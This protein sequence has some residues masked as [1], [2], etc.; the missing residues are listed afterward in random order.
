MRGASSASAL[1]CVWS[2]CVSRGKFGDGHKIEVSY[3]EG[4]ALAATTSVMGLVPVA[5]KLSDFAGLIIFKVAATCNQMRV[6]ELFEQMEARP[7]SAGISDWAMR[8]TSM[9]EVFLRVATASEVDNEKLVAVTIS[10]TADDPEAGLPT[11]EDLPPCQPPSPP[12]SANS[13]RRDQVLP[14]Q[15]TDLESMG[16]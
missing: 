4:S 16:A 14:M 11:K 9:E 12:V 13:P 5:N 3:K 10:R 6:S 15:Q 7:M 1:R 2:T 8:Q